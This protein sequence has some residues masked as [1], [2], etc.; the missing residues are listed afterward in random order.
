M[1]RESRRINL[2]KTVAVLEDRFCED[3]EAA[4]RRCAAG[5][6]QDLFGHNELPLRSQYGKRARVW[7]ADADALLELGN[8]IDEVRGKLGLPAFPPYA[9]YIEYRK[10]RNAQAP[11]QH[12][13][14]VDFLKELDDKKG[15]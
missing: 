11:G 6:S 15:R 9:R 13:L 5:G 4:L 7:F 10:R 1:S 2:E 3:L 14:A 12:Q 8:E